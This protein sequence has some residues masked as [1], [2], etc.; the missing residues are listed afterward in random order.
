MSAI[1]SPIDKRFKSD[2]VERLGV[3][4]IIEGYRDTFGIDIRPF[5]NGDTLE[6]YQCSE[7]GL[8]FYHGI[9]PGDGDFY[10]KLME[11]D[12]YYDPW[13]WEHKTIKA[14]LDPSDDILEVGCGSGGFLT[15]IKGSTA[16]AVGL[17]LNKKAVAECVQKGLNVRSEN[18]RDYSNAHPNA[19][20]WVVSFQVVE[21]IQDVGEFLRDSVR[22]LKPG[23]TLVVSV[24]NNDSF[25]RHSQGDW[26]N[27]PPHHMNLWNNTSLINIAPHIGCTHQQSIFEPLQDYHKS[28]YVN[29]ILDSGRSEINTLPPVFRGLAYKRFRQVLKNWV[30]NEAEN[31][32][33][34]SVLALYTKDTGQ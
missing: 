11:I 23:G 2:L 7:T 26:L 16:N 32:R 29:S 21:H 18:L 31:I 25:M 28:W 3:K 27:M 22:L 24:P 33:G 4:K 5:V 34:H 9:E 6:I 10:G 8:R 12:W 1:S 13:K 30:N 15:G 19:Y 17:E 20:D 14:M